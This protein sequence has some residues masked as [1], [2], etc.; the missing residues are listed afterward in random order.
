MLAEVSGGDIAFL[1][2]LIVGVFAIFQGAIKIIQLF[3][4]KQAT[5]ESVWTDEEREL[6]A[7]M[8]K[9]TAESGQNIKQLSANVTELSRNTAKTADQVTALQ[10]AVSE[11]AAST[12]TLTQFLIAQA[13]RS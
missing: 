8:I 10:I 1:V 5:K 6:I 7:T 3:I 9:S 4:P 12:K 2:G 11:M 13:G